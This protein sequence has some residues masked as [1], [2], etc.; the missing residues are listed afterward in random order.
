MPFANALRERR[1]Q[2]IVR[3]TA[4]LAFFFLEWRFQ[5]VPRLTLP[6]FAQERGRI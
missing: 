6:S 4:F 3:V 1:V 2:G 5:K